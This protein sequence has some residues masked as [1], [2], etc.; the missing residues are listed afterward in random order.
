MNHQISLIVEQCV[1]VLK[2]ATL[3]CNFLVS[4]DAFIYIYIFFYQLVSI[5]FQSISKI[6]NKTTF[7]GKIFRRNIFIIFLLIFFR[8]EKK[9]KNWKQVMHKIFERKWNRISI[10]N[11]VVG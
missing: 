3:S 2:V 6:E 10:E 7:R 5:Q 9:K 1:K 11:C 8:K 4:S